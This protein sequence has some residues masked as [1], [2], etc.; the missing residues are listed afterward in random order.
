MTIRFEDVGD[1]VVEL[2]GKVKQ[3]YFPELRSAQIKV[4]YDTKKRMSGG[5]VVLARIQ[6]TNELQ[7]HLTIDE[8]GSDFGYDYFM[9]LDKLIWDNS[10]E[11]D[12]IRI[13]RHTIQY[14]DVDM[15]KK[16]PYGIRGCEIETFYDEIKRNE[17]DPK[18]QDRLKSIAESL[19]D[20]ENEKNK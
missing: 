12:K 2:V 18:W 20:R 8:S 17:D 16:N 13:I 3:E 7:R 19:Y 14:A 10:T 5:N 11:S 4:F 15:E 6:K 1:E 9:Y